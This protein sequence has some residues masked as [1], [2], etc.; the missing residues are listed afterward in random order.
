MKRFRVKKIKNEKAI[1][2]VVLIVTIIILLILAGISI[3][4]LKQV[5]LFDKANQA[6]QKNENAQ[7]I[8]ILIDKDGKMY[9][10]WSGLTVNQGKGIRFSMT[11][12]S[13]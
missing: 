1:T 9:N 4:A 7:K 13:E 10:Y 8:N 11:Y 6:K 5:G 3:A 12:I 2:L